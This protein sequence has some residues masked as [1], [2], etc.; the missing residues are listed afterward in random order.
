MDLNS[1]TDAELQPDA[2]STALASSPEALG[3]TASTADA[4][5]AAL[6]EPAVVHILQSVNEGDQEAFAAANAGVVPD[7]EPQLG[8][9]PSGQP[10]EEL[11]ASAVT[12]T[13]TV[14]SVADR[15]VGIVDTDSSVEPSQ[16]AAQ[17]GRSRKRS[18][19]WGLPA[20]APAE[21]AADAGEDTQTGRKKRRSRWEEPG[22]AAIADRSQLA[23]VDLSAGSG[24]PHEIV[25][26]GG[27]KVRNV[28]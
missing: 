28:S 5:Q 7:S 11:A 19:R 12:G 1:K 16:D 9:P 17:Q 10:A 24:F 2:S 18:A 27:I 20:N 23:V 8:A 15:E 13:H 21:P 4:A 3:Q 6:G 14:T 25:L 26:A 22:L